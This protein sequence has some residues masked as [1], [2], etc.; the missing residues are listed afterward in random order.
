VREC[1]D[2][3]NILILEA[4][5]AESYL[6]T[7]HPSVPHKGERNHVAAEIPNNASAL[8]W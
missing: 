2:I 8:R 6:P 3:D 7:P 4:V 1:A 5:I